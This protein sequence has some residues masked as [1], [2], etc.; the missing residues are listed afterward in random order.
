MAV[1]RSVGRSVGTGRQAG[2]WDSW[3]SCSLFWTSLVRIKAAE[4][5]EGGSQSYLEKASKGGDTV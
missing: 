3:D 4:E 1:G 2:S 5:R